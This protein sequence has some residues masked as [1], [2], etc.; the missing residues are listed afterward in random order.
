G[1]LVP[2]LPQ[3]G[4]P[5]GA[6]PPSLRAQGVV[7]DDDH[8]ALLDRR[9]DLRG[10]RLHDLSAEHLLSRRPPLPGGPYLI[11]G[12]GRS[13]IAAGLALRARGESVIATDQGSPDVG[14]LERV[15][16]IETHLR[17][18]GTELLSRV[19]TLIKS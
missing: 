10:E 6:D 13:G 16:E 5:D 15:G 7:G 1:L 11:V 2:D 3:A 9:G 18:D 17:T 12:L 4:L 19:R 8:P 14:A